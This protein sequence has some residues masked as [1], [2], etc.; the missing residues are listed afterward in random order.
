MP[1][2]GMG[3]HITN[4]YDAVTYQDALANWKIS[5]WTVIGFFFTLGF[6]ILQGRALR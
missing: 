5:D 2:I 3:K 6:I 4:T 1:H